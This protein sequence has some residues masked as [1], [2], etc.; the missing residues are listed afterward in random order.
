MPNIKTQLLKSP[1]VLI[2]VLNFNNFLST[3][4]C[5]VSIY[6][7]DYK[8]YEIL[9]IDN[10]STDCSYN[11]LTNAFPLI[12]VIR[13]KKNEGYAAGHYIS[14]EYGLSKNF[15]LI[16]ILNNDLIVFKKTLSNLIIEYKKFGDAL[17]GSLTLKSNNPEIIDFGGGKTSNLQ[18]ALNYNDYENCR[19]DEYLTLEKTRPVQTIEGSSFLIPF[20]VITKF[21]FM[22][23]KF[24]MY[25]E[26]ISYCFRLGKKDV[27]SII[28]VNSK[29]LHKKGESLKGNKH[30]EDYYRRRNHLF[31]LKEH[32]N[33]S[34]ILNVFKLTG[35][36]TTLFYLTKYLFI[37]RKDDVYYIH[38]ANF[39]AIIGKNGKL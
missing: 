28:V 7:S 35:L 16:W 1:K 21:G 37:N 29:V 4:D 38:L 19:L 2:S 17:F 8:N 11:D 15:D 24:F 13:S 3:K 23:K 27:K 12:K 32:Y 34:I 33:E 9:I 14:V 6:G 10:Y 39:H 20:D 36:A 22:D 25:A 30:L 18:T 31:F 26:E 5:V